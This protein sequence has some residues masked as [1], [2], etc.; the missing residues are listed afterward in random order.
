MFASAAAAFALLS[1]VSA[2][3]QEGAG[4]IVEA[5][6]LAEAE[7]GQLALDNRG[8]EQANFSFSHVYTDGMVLQREPHPAS[9]WG[10]AAPGAT[11]TLAVAVAVA[12]TDPDATPRATPLANPRSSATATATAGPS[13]A[14]RASLPPQPASTAA[15]TVTATSGGTTLTLTDVLFG[16][17]YVCS[18]QSNM[19]FSVAVPTNDEAAEAKIFAAYQSDPGASASGSYVTSDAA[20]KDSVNYPNLRFLVVGNK[21]DCPAPVADFYPSPG[22][23]NSALRLAHPWQKPSP[24][25]IGG[26]KDVMGGNGAGEM[27]ATCYYWGL[28]LHTTQKIPIGLIHTSYGGSA[29]EDWIS[30]EVLGDGKTGLCPGPVVHSMGLPSQ[31][32]NGQL[33]PLLNTTIKGAIWYQGES[34]HGQNELYSCR[35]EQ[36]MTEWRRQWHLGTGGATDPEFAMGFVQ[37][38]PMTNDE[39]DDADSFLIRMGQTANFGYA[40]N[41]RWPNAFMSTGFDLMNPPGTKCIAGCIHIFNKQAVAHRLALAARSLIYAEKLVF[42]GPRVVSA[43]VSAGTLTVQYG[44]IGTEGTGIRLR[45]G[46]GFE[47]SSTPT[48]PTG[49]NGTWTRVNVTS[50]TKDTVMVAGI[51]GP[52]AAVRYGWEDSPSIFTNT[53][54]AVFNGEGLPA[55]PSLFQTVTTA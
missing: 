10:W 9:I 30:A 6:Q 39:G 47:V 48:D 55:T 49:K 50:A 17:V 38:G 15:V 22:N 44:P 32:W 24:A 46:Y 26:G 8:A 40:P 35:Y 51:T 28:E 19:A 1:A 54:P 36:L 20:I 25:T 7:A 41:A 23:N 34:N 33:A 16:D 45:G 11:V 31:Q 53:G 21:H 14:W 2:A 27:S 3:G 43:S 29:V 12:V 37:I 18:G 4:T 5:A 52:V 42:S 13:G